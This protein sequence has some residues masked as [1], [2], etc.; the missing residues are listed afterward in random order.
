[1][2]GAQE[3]L[4]ASQFDAATVL[5]VLA[6]FAVIILDRVIYRIWRPPSPGANE[7]GCISMQRYWSSLR[8]S[9]L[10]TLFGFTHLPHLATALPRCQLVLVTRVKSNHPSPYYTFPSRL[11]CIGFTL[12]S[13]A[14]STASGDRPPQVRIGLYRVRVRVRVRVKVRVRVRVRLGLGLRVKG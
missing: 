3:S 1:M 14:S 12:S 8:Y 6:A 10:R 2:L 11:G 5:S 7:Y 13:T 4:A 9:F